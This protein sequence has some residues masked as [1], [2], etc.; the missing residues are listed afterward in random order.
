MEKI[1]SETSLT[2]PKRFNRTHLLNTISSPTDETI[3]K[4]HILGCRPKPSTAL[5]QRIRRA[6]FPPKT[7]DMIFASISGY[8]GFLYIM[9][10]PL[11]L[12]M[13]SRQY[14][15]LLVFL[16]KNLLFAYIEKDFKNI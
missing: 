7:S 6:A 15:Q 13:L 1:I 11:V 9:I 12:D 4:R 14:Q 8:K 10:E 2:Q 5:E 3:R 16:F